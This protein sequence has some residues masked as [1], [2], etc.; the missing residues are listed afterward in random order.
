M[1]P[2]TLLA[3]VLLTHPTVT[4][5][6]VR[7]SV[8][9][10]FPLIRKAVA[11]HTEKQTC[12]GCHNQ[13]FPMIA[14]ARGPERGF[15][16]PTA[17]I[18]SLLDHLIEFLTTHRE[19]YESGTGTGGGVDTAGWALFT[20]ENGKRKPDANTNAVVQY[21]LKAQKDRDHW[22]CSS[23]RPPSEASHFATTFLAVRGLNTWAT[24]E[25]REAAKKRITSARQ[26]LEKTSPTDTEDHV[27]RLLALREA[28]SDT[29]VV[30]RAGEQLLQLQRTDGG[31]SQRSQDGSDAYA[32]GSAWAA[33]CW[34]Q[35]IS[36][37]S[38]QAR[39][40]L[41]FLLRTQH[42]D[43]TWLVRS[44]SKPFQK[45]YETGF[46]HEKDQFISVTA[47]AWATTALLESLPKR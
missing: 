46:P 23:D 37:N 3:A 7:T 39:A 16:I 38:T 22:R 14:F 12:F 43:G 44:R 24:D 9:R 36:H 26:W 40:G 15:D 4:P 1:T 6:T 13:A 27:F 32:T 18:D 17:E 11:G 8:D 2:T 41:A 25:H 33:L 19:K 20:L 42:E 47:S 45:Y 34:T 5:E 35:M 28:G 31:W 10:A 30:R 21:L 29:E